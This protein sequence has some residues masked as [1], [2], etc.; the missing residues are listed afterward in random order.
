LSSAL[1]EINSGDST[2]ERLM[3]LFVGEVKDCKRS[4]GLDSF[5]FAAVEIGTLFLEITLSF[6]NDVT[7]KVL[8]CI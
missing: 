8:G 6:S 5:G 2:S 7:G 3:R 4:C 1:L